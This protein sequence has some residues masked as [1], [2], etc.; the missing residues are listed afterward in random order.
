MSN[1]AIHPQLLTDCHL[2]GRIRSAHLLLH[3]NASLPWFILVPET[4]CQ[5]L[6]DLP[7][8]TRE[9]LLTDA[10]HVADFI[11]THFELKKINVAALGNV[12]PQLHLHVIGRDPADPCWPNPVWGNLTTEEDWPANAVDDFSAALCQCPD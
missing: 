7:E 2:L 10:K 8:S 12:V 11:K 1:F 6:L 5:D 9:A 4:D 3:R